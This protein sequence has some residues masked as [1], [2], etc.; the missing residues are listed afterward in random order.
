MLIH[1]QVNLSAYWGVGSN[2][3]KTGAV[4]LWKRQHNN[5]LAPPVPIHL[6]K[7]HG[8]ATKPGFH[9][10]SALWYILKLLVSGSWQ[11]CIMIYLKLQVLASWLGF[12]IPI[13]PKINPHLHLDTTYPQAKF[14][15]DWSK[16]TQVIVKKTNVWHPPACLTTDIPNLIT[17]FHLAKT[18][19]TKVH[20][21]KIWTVDRGSVKWKFHLTR[22]HMTSSGI[23]PK[24]IDL[25]S[26]ELHTKVNN[27]S[28]IAIM[29]LMFVCKAGYDQTQTMY[30]STPDMLF[31][32][33]SKQFLFKGECYYHE[34]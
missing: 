20:S 33:W 31:T 16:E 10:T 5:P 23:D 25:D 29:L 18:Q 27:K 2:S 8:N 3:Y 9:T 6:N 24:L 11:K 26:K 34:L 14:D 22:L 28:S 7:K 30:L 12:Y 1:A 15:V 4:P 17:R 32:P 13:D 21:T 19:L